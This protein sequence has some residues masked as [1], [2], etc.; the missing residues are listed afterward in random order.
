MMLGT[1]DQILRQIRQINQKV[2]LKSIVTS[3]PFM[4]T[5]GMTSLILGGFGGSYMLQQAEEGVYPPLSKSAFE[6]FTTRPESGVKPPAKPN[7]HADE[8]PEPKDFLS[9]ASVSSQN[10]LESDGFSLLGLEA[11]ATSPPKSARVETMQYD[12]FAPLE[13]K[14]PYLIPPED[15][16]QNHALDSTAQGDFPFFRDV[17]GSG[18]NDYLAP[19]EETTEQITSDPILPDFVPE[20]S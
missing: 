18:A 17:I 4:V 14:R 6:I 20:R 1:K 12:P 9:E 11:G 15:L 2:Q 5:V 13:A 3:A 7:V 10:D 19:T 16:T 8:Q